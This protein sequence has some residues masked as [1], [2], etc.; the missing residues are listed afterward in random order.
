MPTITLTPSAYTL[1]STTYLTVSNA[2]NMYVNT[3]S[4]NYATIQNTRTST[5]VYYI[6]L[7]DFNLSDIPSNAVV[8]SYTVRLKAYES[9][10]STS[11]TYRPVVT[12]NDNTST[13][14]YYGYASALSTSASVCEFT[15]DATWAELAAEG[16]DLSIRV[17]NRRS[18]RNT[19]SYVYIYGAEI[20]V[21]YI[22]P[23]PRTITSSLNGNGTIS[24]SG[25]ITTYDGQE[26]ELTITPTDVSE[27]VS[28]TVDGVDQTSSLVAH[29]A[30]STASFTAND[31]TTSGIQSGS[32]YAAYCIGYS[33]EDPSS[34]GTSSNMYASSSSTG[35]AEYSF[36]FSSIPSN[37]VIEDIVVN[38]YGH[39]ES[40]TIDST[41]VSSITLYQGSTAISEEVDFPSTNNSIITVSPTD[42]P[43]RSELSNVTLRHYVGYYG[44]LVLGITF[45]VTYSVGTG[46]DHYTYTFTV[47]GDRVIVVTIGSS[48]TDTL[49]IR[50]NG[51]SWLQVAKAYV[52][53]NNGTYTEQDIKTVFNTSTRYVLIE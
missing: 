39:R 13:S 8:N 4:T 1:S 19:T 11:S 23:T 25:T 17:S 29:G 48:V 7:H 10:A 43:T 35:Y 14:S 44:G 45:N 53:N 12:T 26:Y 18:S 20:E 30:G 52:R 40:S 51:G 27:Q 3:S 34:S 47:S 32:S 46:V 33:A 38:C 50:I 6:Y 31:H 42:M 41:H 21:D 36:D 37:A 22:I 9:G 49:Y 2:S 24:P 16:N 5:T 28:I 15:M